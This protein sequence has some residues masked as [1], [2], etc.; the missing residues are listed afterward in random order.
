MN[1]L[2]I[3]LGIFLLLGLYKGIKNGLLIE[4]A[5]IVA[6]VIGIYGAV[7]FSYYAVAYLDDKVT[8]SDQSI[9]L[10]AFAVT[11]IVIVLIISLAGRLLTKLASL[12]MLGIVNRILGGIFGLLKVAF[13][14]SV[15]MMFTSAL[16]FTVIDP[17]TREESVL[18][19][20]VEPIAPLVL[21]NILKQVNKLKLENSENQEYDQ[22]QNQAL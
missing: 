3:I 11:F 17:Q 9:N 2:D 4:L 21:P 6:L 18:F 20:T 10:L 12:I 8:W 22:A 1:Y 19:K 14:L 15:I 16:T 13:I 5:S 7:N